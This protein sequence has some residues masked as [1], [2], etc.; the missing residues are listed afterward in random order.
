MACENRFRE[1][2]IKGGGVGQGAQ[3]ESDLSW[4]FMQVSGIDVVEVGPFIV[5][6]RDCSLGALLSPLTNYTAQLC[7]P[8]PL[9]TT[10]SG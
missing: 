9:L 4:D 10:L 8:R 6:I 1:H 5:F 3:M 2:A 7:Q